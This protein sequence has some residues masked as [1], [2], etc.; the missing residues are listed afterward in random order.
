MGTRI[1]GVVA[2][3]YKGVKYRSTLEANTAETLDLLGIPFE[4]ETKR[5][6]LQ[7]GFK[8]KYQKNKVIRVTYT[9]DFILNGNI[10]IECKGF[11]TP[12][13]R[14][15]KKLVFKYLSEKEP[16]TEF[17]QIKDCRKS[18]LELLDNCWNLFGYCIQVT[19]KHIIKGVYQT[20]EFSSIK[21]AMNCLNLKGKP[22]GAIMSSLIGKKQYAYGYKWKLIK[23]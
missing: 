9:P 8:C 2:K 15:K 11:E 13:W 16:D 7:E 12:E 10:L 14:L 17:Y 20:A 1:Q 3:E 18:L 4:Y 6:E 21:E 5:I 23:V 19:S 22:L